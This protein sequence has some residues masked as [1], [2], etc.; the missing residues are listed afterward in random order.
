MTLTKCYA[1]PRVDLA[2]DPDCGVWTSATESVRFIR[3]RC[4]T[5]YNGHACVASDFVR[6]STLIMI[7]SGGPSFTSEYSRAK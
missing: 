7:H 2:E 1:G 4:L 6:Y 3:E 5:T